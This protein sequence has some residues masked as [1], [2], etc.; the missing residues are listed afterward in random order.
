MYLSGKGT[1]VNP[2]EALRWLEQSAEKGNAYAAFQ[3]A[4]LLEDG[5]F[6]PKDE[7]H[8]YK[9]Y[10]V[11][12]TGFL[13]LVQKEPDAQLEHRIG[14][15]YLNSKGTAVNPPEAL[16][17]FEQSAEKGNAYSAF[18]AAKLLE[19]G[20]LV[21]KDEIRAN[22]LYSVA[23]A[24]FLGLEQKEPDAQLEHRIGGMYLNGKGTTVNS[25]E[26]LRWLEQSAEKGNAYAAFQTAKLLED[27]KLVPKDEI[28]AN[29]L[30]SVALAGFLKLEQKEPDAQ[31][32]HRIG[33]MYLNGKGT[34]ANPLEAMRWFEQSAEKGNA[35]AA[36]Q[37]AQLLQE[38]KWI[39]RNDNRAQIYFN[40]ALNGFIAIDREDPDSTMEYRIGQMLA[41]GTGALVNFDAARHWYSLSADK[42][43]PYAQFQL[44]RIYQSGEWVIKN[45]ELAQKLYS[46]AL[47][48]FL[49]TLQDG[50]DANLQYRIGTMFEFGLGV[51]KNVS[52]AK[53]WYSAAANEGSESA[54]NRL[55]QINSIASKVAVN[56]VLSLFRAFARNMGNEINDSTTHKYRQDRKLLQ[57]QK[58]LKMAH[59]NTREQE[60]SI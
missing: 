17:W 56:S 39:P 14:S 34:A 3:T 59:G 53:Q 16:R 31:L 6:I 1:A 52:A 26:A 12:L 8:A 5:K 19:D 35:F 42:G 25:M 33:S 18:Q 51:E 38:G 10:S 55:N 48:G 22:K 47:K 45:E 54:V 57:K 40:L 13:E 50:P 41:R 21:P 15:M 27:G 43:N 49:K 9:L 46:S 58:A 37:A 7:I 4:K 28:R 30:Y 2:P 44:A 20:K 11:A 23:L 29:K 36:Y 24:G 60:Q 32:E